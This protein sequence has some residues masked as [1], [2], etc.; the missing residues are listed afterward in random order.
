LSGLAVSQGQ[1]R[2]AALAAIAVKSPDHALIPWPDVP[3][4]GQNND[5]ITP[6]Q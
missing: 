2:L 6:I 1:P 3:R 4:K 5:M